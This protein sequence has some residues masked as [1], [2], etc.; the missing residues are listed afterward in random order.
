M[1]CYSSPKSVIHDLPVKSFA[2]TMSAG[3][4]EWLLDRRCSQGKP[5]KSEEW[6][7]WGPGNCNE[8]F[9]RTGNSKFKDLKLK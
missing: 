2:E 4:G 8:L 7:F 9:Y 1:I 6:L 5:L 3:N